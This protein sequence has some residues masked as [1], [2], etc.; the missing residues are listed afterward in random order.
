MPGPSNFTG[1]AG[2]FVSRYGGYLDPEATLIF[3]IAVGVAADEEI[4]VHSS[5]LLRAMG[6][7]LTSFQ[8][9]SRK[10]RF[11]RLDPF[12]TTDTTAN[13]PRTVIA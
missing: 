3:R 8:P 12:S 5:Q 13:A 1:S 6:S 11:E 9:S 10:I 7:A 2:E 4:G